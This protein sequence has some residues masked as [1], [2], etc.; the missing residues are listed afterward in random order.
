M[1]FNHEVVPVI[2]KSKEIKEELLDILIGPKTFVPI[3]TKKDHQVNMQNLFNNHIEALLHLGGLFVI[4]N[5]G[6]IPIKIKREEMK[7]FM[8]EHLAYVRSL[9]FKIISSKDFHEKYRN[10]KKDDKLQI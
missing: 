10:L 6:K 9:F 8:H 4:S 2:L 7:E 5:N 3:N 1:K